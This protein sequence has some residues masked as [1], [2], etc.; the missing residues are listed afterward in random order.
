M[1]KEKMAKWGTLL[2]NE[3]AL[4]NLFNLLYSIHIYIFMVSHY[5]VLVFVSALSYASPFRHTVDNW[6]NEGAK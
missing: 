2:D 1:L 6:C 4:F 3:L 5:L